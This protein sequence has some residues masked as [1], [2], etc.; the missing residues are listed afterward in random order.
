LGLRRLNCRTAVLLELSVLTKLLFCALV[1]PVCDVPKICSAQGRHVSL[2][3]LGNI[4]GQC[5]CWFSA[6]VLGI[7]IS[8]W[9]EFSLAHHAFYDRRNDRQNYYQLLA[10]AETLA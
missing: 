3:R 6:L 5:P 1:C 4:L 9:L 8:P 10:D 7:S 2:L